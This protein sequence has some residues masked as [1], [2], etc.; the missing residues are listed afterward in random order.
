MS[1][2]RSAFVEPPLLKPPAS[3]GLRRDKLRGCHEWGSRREGS[4]RGYQRANTNF[5][6]FTPI[7]RLFVIIRVFTAAFL[8]KVFGKRDR[9]AKGPTLDRA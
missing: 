6:K 7:D 2:H 4:E 5:T 1:D 9:R 3:Q 8:R